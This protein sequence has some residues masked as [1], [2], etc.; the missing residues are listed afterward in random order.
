MEPDSPWKVVRNCEALVLNC[1]WPSGEARSTLPAVSDQACRAPPSTCQSEAI[2]AG[3]VVWL[4]AADAC[5]TTGPISC[6]VV[7][8]WA[9]PRVVANC[10]A[11]WQNAATAG[12]ALPDDELDE[13]EDEPVLG[14]AELEVSALVDSALSSLPDPSPLLPLLQA[15]S[16][17][18]A[19]AATSAQRDREGNDRMP[20]G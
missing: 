9:W 3:G 4:K 5:C 6:G 8:D 10:S 11:C 15:V 1:C 17:T 16:R 14:A 13:V 20:G 12:S 2:S 7:R 19:A 18:V